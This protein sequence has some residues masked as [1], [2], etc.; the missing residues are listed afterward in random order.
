M[1]SGRKP[2]LSGDDGDDGDDGGDVR[3]G[4]DKEAGHEGAPVSTSRV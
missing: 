3:R 4:G 2:L 1:D